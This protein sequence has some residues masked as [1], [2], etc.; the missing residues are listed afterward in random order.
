MYFWQRIGI[1]LWSIKTDDA[2]LISLFFTLLHIFCW[3]IFFLE[4]TLTEPLYMIG[5]KQVLCL[6]ISIKIYQIENKTKD[7]IYKY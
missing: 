2:P 5:I 6:N 3:I 1:S 7:S 4:S